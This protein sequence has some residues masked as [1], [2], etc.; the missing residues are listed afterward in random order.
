MNS[1]VGKLEDNSFIKQQR[2]ELKI[3]ESKIAGL[4]RK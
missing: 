2:D 4:K 1:V 3:F